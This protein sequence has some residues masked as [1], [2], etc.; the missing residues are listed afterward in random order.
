[1]KI[2]LPEFQNDLKEIEEE[3]LQIGGDKSKDEILKLACV[4]KFFKILEKV[5]YNF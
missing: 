4:D 2:L 1:M 3:L 5:K